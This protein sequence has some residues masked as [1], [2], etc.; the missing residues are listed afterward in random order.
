M[1]RLPQ[2]VHC[3]FFKL[4]FSPNQTSRQI[5]KN[6]IW[7]RLERWGRIF[8]PP[9]GS[10]LVVKNGWMDGLDGIILVEESKGVTTKTTTTKKTKQVQCR[11]EFF[12]QLPGLRKFMLHHLNN[13]QYTK[14]FTMETFIPSTSL[15]Q[16]EELNSVSKSLK[17]KKK[18]SQ[19]LTGENLHNC[20][21]S[22]PGYIALTFPLCNT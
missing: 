22:L 1:P 18:M 9:T 21:V 8:P 7:D 20:R 14:Q 10:F 4:P 6:L 2:D 16:N 3:G 13:L 5:P 12:S 11:C 17:S 19:L 15:S